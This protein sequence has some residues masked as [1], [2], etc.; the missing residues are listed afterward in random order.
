[1]ATSLQVAAIQRQEICERALENPQAVLG[2]AKV[3]DHLGL[4]QADGVGR[5]GIAKSRMEFL[6]HGGAAD[7]AAPFQHLYFQTGARQV[8]GAGEA[9]MPPAHDD[10]IEAHSTVTDLARL[11]GLSTSVPRSSAV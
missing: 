10:R 7:H 2:Q 11:R 8:A 3:A 9:V 4:Q 1:L 6:C 5:H